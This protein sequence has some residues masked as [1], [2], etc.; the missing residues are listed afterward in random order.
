MDCSQQES[1]V[2]VYVTC[3]KVVAQSLKVLCCR[4]CLAEPAMHTAVLCLFQGVVQ[5]VG[6]LRGVGVLLGSL[7][8]SFYDLCNKVDSESA[9]K[10]RK[11]TMDSELSTKDYQDAYVASMKDR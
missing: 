3:N 9:A 8:V 7:E 1:E 5:G 11:A 2:K 4:S 10:Y 6:L